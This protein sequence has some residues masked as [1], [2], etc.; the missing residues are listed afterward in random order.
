[1]KKLR[2][3]D[4]SQEVFDLYDDYAHSRIDRRKFMDKL[5]A[6]AVGGLT[7]PALMSFIL[8]DY[9]NKIQVKKDDNRLS[10]EYILYDSP[11]GAGEMK[12]LLS[13]PSATEEK[14]PGIIVVHDAAKV[15]V[16][17]LCAKMS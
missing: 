11:K 9:E 7:I 16:W 15:K 4:I 14:L 8:P 10:S 17:S 13:R 1:M 3:E 12:G 6:Y 5:S 2:K